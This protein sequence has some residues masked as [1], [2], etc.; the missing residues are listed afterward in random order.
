MQSASVGGGGCWGS[1]SGRAC[2]HAPHPSM[3][4]NRSSPGVPYVRAHALLKQRSCIRQHSNDDARTALCGTVVHDHASAGEVYLGRGARQRHHAASE[5]R[6]VGVEAGV[7]SRQP[8]L[9]KVIRWNETVCRCQAKV[10][11]C[12]SLCKSRGLSIHPCRGR[13]SQLETACPLSLARNWEH[14]A[15]GRIWQ[16]ST[17]Q[18]APEQPNL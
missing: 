7:G 6:V 5:C 12:I 3:S 11:V 17:K 4:T 8:G 15:C 1:F 10:A 13:R 16:P 2:T 18:Q 14:L 9:R